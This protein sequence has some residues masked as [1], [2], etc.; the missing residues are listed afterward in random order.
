MINLTLKERLLADIDAAESEIIG[1]LQRLIQFATVNP[2]G[3]EGQHQAFVAAELEALGLEVSMVEA[4]PGR[5]N[6]I[7]VLKGTGGGKNLLHYAGHADV[8]TAGDEG[9]W[10]YPP[11]GGEVHDGWIYGRG[12]VDHK[13][14]I[15]ASLGALR[16]I[17]ASGIRLQGDLI[18]LVP[19]DEECGS[20]A[21]T[22]H[23]L[24]NHLLYGDMGIYASAG[25][26][27][28]ILISCAGSVQFEVTV[29]GRTAHGG[30]SHKGINAIEKAS[31]LVL[32][33]QSMTFTKINPLWMPEHEKDRLAPSR[34]G[35]MTVTHIESSS[36]AGSVPD[37]CVIRA[38]RRLVPNE[39]VVE[40]KVQIEAV[41][42]RLRRED[43]NFVA[44]LCY[45]AAVNGLN[46]APDDPLVQ[47]VSEAVR[48]IGLVPEI[49][50]SSG[51][52]DARWIVDALDI[53]FVSYGAGW[54]GPDGKLCLHVE[55]EAI[56]VPDL[57]GMARA[58]AMIMLRVCGVSE[59]IV[60]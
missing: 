48:D 31:K 60:T 18:F 29:R 22:K 53:P 3:N 6:V 14:P 24:A 20:Y 56:T 23:L 13:A 57:M 46:T 21:G 59:S 17:I 15:A 45:V 28:Q 1:T 12:A 38:S 9:K 41:L 34:T 52:F 7:G 33:L 50:G 8:V 32:A 19:V 39:T 51:G 35:A 25:F 2:P 5:P 55:N 43:P 42:D 10:A 54:N 11:F 30:W 26:L 40:A 27:Q 37:V 44:E 58:Y 16:A 49:G 4:Q 47:H 36:P